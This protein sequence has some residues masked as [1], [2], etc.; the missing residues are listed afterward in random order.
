MLA[1]VVLAFVGL[2]VFLNRLDPGRTPSDGRWVRWRWS[3][4]KKKVALIVPAILGL[5]VLVNLL[6]IGG[7]PKEKVIIR[8][9]ITQCRDEQGRA[10]PAPWGQLNKEGTPYGN[11]VGGRTIFYDDKGHEISCSGL[12]APQRPGG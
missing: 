9:V 3:A 8:K 7:A 1:L 5:V 4:S 2:V 10:T 6:D 12:L 11:S